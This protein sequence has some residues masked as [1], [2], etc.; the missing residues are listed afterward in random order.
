M[1]LMLSNLIVWCMYDVWWHTM[2]SFWFSVDF[3]IL[4]SIPSLWLTKKSYI[5]QKL[6]WVSSME[7]SIIMHRSLNRELSIA[8][9]PSILTPAPIHY[10][11]SSRSGIFDSQIQPHY[12]LN[13]LL[14]GHEPRVKPDSSACCDLYFPAPPSHILNWVGVLHFLNE[15]SS[16]L[17]HDRIFV[18]AAHFAWGSPSVLHSYWINSLSVS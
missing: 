2:L 8:L 15:P 5:S 6:T 18:Q 10:H 1:K 7:N 3:L 12:L 11:P 17:F 9:H 16:F 14:T 4:V 13:K